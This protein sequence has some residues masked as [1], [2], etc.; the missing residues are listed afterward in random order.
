MNPQ[1]LPPQTASPADDVI[2][3]LTREGYHRLAE[4]LR[5]LLRPLVNGSETARAHPGATTVEKEVPLFTPFRPPPLDQGTWMDRARQVAIAHAYL[6]KE[7]S[8][9]SVAWLEERCGLR[10]DDSQVERAAVALDSQIRAWRRRRLPRPYWLFVHSWRERVFQATGAECWPATLVVGIDT[11]G[12]RLAADFA[13]GPS[14]EPHWD[15]M[16]KSLDARGVSPEGGGMTGRMVPEMFS[17]FASKWPAA[18]LQACQRQFT[19]RMTHREPE[20]PKVP[21]VPFK[22]TTVEHRAV[23]D[24]WVSADHPLRD[25]MEAPGSGRPGIFAVADLP[26]SLQ[27]A[28]CS[29]SWV[30][31]ELRQLRRQALQDDLP[32]G[33]SM[34]SR[35]LAAA[36]IEWEG[37]LDLK[38]PFV[39][40]EILAEAQNA[41]AAA[42]IA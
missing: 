26:A 11:H 32:L 19:S 30:E 33:P 39:D 17:A 1:L 41:I 22:G 4:A 34:K 18:R 31:R 20:S 37:R 36:V 28:L 12:Y 21:R 23:W 5:D 3:V 13:F 42:R 16:A 10:F 40:P 7:A 9:K 15:E 25:W 6:R 24:R 14:G 35:L 38:K 2:R 27:S 29:T 8:E